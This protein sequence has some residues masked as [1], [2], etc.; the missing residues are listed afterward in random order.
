MTTE[1]PIATAEIGIQQL[2]KLLRCIST[3]QINEILEILPTDRLSAKTLGVLS[4]L[5]HSRGPTIGI[6][7]KRVLFSRKS[8]GESLQ[9][10]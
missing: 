9:T 7:H 10:G 5:C 6:A 4:Q 8:C 1:R 2:L 3:L